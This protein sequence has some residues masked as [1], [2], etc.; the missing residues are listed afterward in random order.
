MSHRFV[1]DPNPTSVKHD[2]RDVTFARI[3]IGQLSFNGLRQFSRPMRAAVVTG[4]T[5][6]QNSSFLPHQCQAVTIAT[7]L[8]SLQWLRIPAKGW[9]G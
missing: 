9:P 4:P 3:V 7:C 5:V 6:T 2:P 1:K 8:Y